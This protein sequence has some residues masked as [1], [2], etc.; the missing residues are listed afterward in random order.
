MTSLVTYKMNKGKIHYHI[1]LNTILF[2]LLL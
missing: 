1:K 2:S